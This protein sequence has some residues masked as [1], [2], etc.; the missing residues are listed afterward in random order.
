MSAITLIYKTIFFQPI[1]NLLVFLYGAIPGTDLGVAIIVL[2]LIVRIILLPLSIKSIHS[3]R[4]MQ[5]L[6]PKL[7]ELQIQFKGEKEKLA[8]ATMELYAKEKVNPLSGCLPL[9]IQL[10]F[11]LAIYHA[12]QSSLKSDFGAN[13]YAFVRNPGALDVKFFGFLDLA[14]ASIPLAVLAGLTQY[15]QTAMLTTNRPPAGAGPGAKDE[16]RMAM[17][18]KQMKY[19]MPA[20]TVFIGASL[21]GGLTLYWLVTNLFT[22]AQQLIFLKKK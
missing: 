4:A 6:Q 12:M 15:W 18:N 1:F 19:L 14:H 8:K 5:D 3:Q 2:T 7:K 11:F 21:P 16:D 17:V 13:L 22:V 20:M 10:P 9:L